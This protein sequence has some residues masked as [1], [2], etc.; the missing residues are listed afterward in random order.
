MFGDNKFMDGQLFVLV[1][2]KEIILNGFLGVEGKV[3][4]WIRKFWKFLV[5]SED[6]LF[7]S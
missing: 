4:C 7:S 1:E 5:L 3:N 2:Q 6:I